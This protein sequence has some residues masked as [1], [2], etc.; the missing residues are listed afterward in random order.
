MLGWAMAA[1][2]A[3]SETGEARAVTLTNGEHL[4]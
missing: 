1:V 3:C 2:T 4:I